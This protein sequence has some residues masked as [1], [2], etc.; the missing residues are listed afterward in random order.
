LE[1]VADGAN[2]RE[3]GLCSGQGFKVANHSVI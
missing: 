1:F 2:E 3:L